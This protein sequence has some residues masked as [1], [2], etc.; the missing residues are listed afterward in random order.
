MLFG[1]WVKSFE[2]RF[3]LHEGD[4]N[5]TFV[6]V[7]LLPNQNEIAVIDT[8]FD[9]RIAVGAENEEVAFAE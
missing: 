5:L 3:I 4:D 7:V 6:C 8:C 2:C 1:F 9:H